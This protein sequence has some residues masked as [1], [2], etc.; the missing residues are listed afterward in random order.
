MPPL[1]FRRTILLRRT[2]AESRKIPD[3]TPKKTAAS[4]LR[5]PPRLPCPCV[6]GLGLRVQAWLE[7]LRAEQGLGV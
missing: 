4:Q 2:R 5:L 3:I 6:R 7:A 1:Q